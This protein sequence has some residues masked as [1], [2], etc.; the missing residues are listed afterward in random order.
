[1]K[2][3]NKT[4]LATLVLTASQAYAENESAQI[5]FAGS[6]YSGSCEVT[7]N[8]DGA[9]AVNSTNTVTLK[10]ISTDD[11]TG[12]GLV[13]ETAQDFSI[14]VEDC[15]GDTGK[16]LELALI[17]DWMDGDIVQALY[18][19]DSGVVDGLGFQVQQT[20]NGAAVTGNDWTNTTLTG[21][22]DS[23]EG[24]LYTFPFQVSYYKT[25]DAETTVTAGLVKASINYLVSY[26]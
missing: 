19:A 16:T 25:A 15:A 23:D 3:L 24:D 17:G 22:V 13:A 12:T 8:V 21:A 1:M 6:I 4:L 7:V 11:L 20:E 18:V 26:Q 9:G 10:A 2:I 14:V 5:N